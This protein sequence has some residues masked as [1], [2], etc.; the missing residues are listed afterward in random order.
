MVQ[1]QVANDLLALSF[2]RL[3]SIQLELDASIGREQ[4]HSPQTS[5]IGVAT[6]GPWHF[7]GFVLGAGGN[8]DIRLWFGLVKKRKQ[9]VPDQSER[10]CV[11]PCSERYV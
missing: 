8:M 5:D 6:L 7:A 2:Y 10:R 11:S 3:A 9:V 1:V 4:R